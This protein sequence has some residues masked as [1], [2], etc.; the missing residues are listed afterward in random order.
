MIRDELLI[1]TGG[2]IKKAVA[3]F[4][5]SEYR[6]IYEIRI[7]NKSP[8]IFRTSEG[9]FFVD[10]NMNKTR[11]INIAVNVSKDDI[12]KT[13]ELMSRYSLYAFDEDLKRGFITIQGGHRA[14]ITGKTVIENGRVKTFG[15]IS[16]INI[17]IAHEIKG[18]SKKIIPYITHDNDIMNT[19]I[20]SPPGYGKTTILRDI[21][22][23]ISD[24][25][26]GVKKPMNVCV[27]DERSEIGGNFMGEF[28]N[29]IGIRT[30]ILD[31]CPKALGM[32]MLLRSMSPDVIAVDEIGR[33]EDVKAI[34]E[35]FNSGVVLICTIHGKSI[36]DVYSKKII[37]NLILAECFERYIVLGKRGNY[38]TVFD[39]K[40]KQIYK[41]D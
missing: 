1:S 29:D 4:G 41:G 21:I 31:S 9:E 30:D 11:D 38:F 7:R 2:V 39:G 22:R 36:D 14:G 37:S 8:V 24:G 6:N 26:S 25:T 20:I 12:N 10:K 35:A 33:D 28:R 40:G 18:C 34:S 17:R 13:M 16:S 19:L 5:D 23:N 15:N 27:V 32:E 3:A